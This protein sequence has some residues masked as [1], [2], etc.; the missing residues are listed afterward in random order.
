MVFRSRGIREQVFSFSQAMFMGI[1]AL[2]ISLSSTNNAF[3]AC[4]D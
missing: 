2:I 3:N 1:G 4:I